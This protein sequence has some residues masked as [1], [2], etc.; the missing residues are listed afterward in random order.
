MVLMAQ[1]QQQLVFDASRLSYRT[2]IPQQFIWPEDE[3]PTPDAAAELYV[4][5]IDLSGDPGEVVRQVG[6]A[7]ELHGFFQVVNHGIEQELLAEAHRCMDTFFTLP[8]PEK[9]RAQRLQGESCGYASSFTGRFASKLPWKETLSFR[10]SSTFRGGGGVVD[11][12]VEKLGEEHRHHGY[13][14][15]YIAS[16][17]INFIYIYTYTYI[18]YIVTKVK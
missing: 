8:L 16:I 14:Y 13:I 7:C 9:Q 15:I 4:P 12:F 3:S 17:F 1:Q 18:E 10:S 6:A 2:D 5:L 11:Y